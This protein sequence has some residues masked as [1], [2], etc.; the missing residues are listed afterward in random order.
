MDVHLKSISSLICVK[1][2]SN[3]EIKKYHRKKIVFQIFLKTNCNYFYYFF[4][5]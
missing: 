5:V 1:N 2:L 4:P 3:F